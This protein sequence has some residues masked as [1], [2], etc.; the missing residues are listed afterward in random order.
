M[1]SPSRTEAFAA[2]TSHCYFIGSGWGDGALSHHM[3]TLARELARRG[4]RV[5]ML[6]HGARGSDDVEVRDRN[7]SMLSWPS[8]RPTTLADAIFLY[9]LARQHKPD[10][11]ISCFAAANLMLLVGRLLNVPCRV[12]W[13]QT[14]TTQIDIDWVES[15]WKMR[16]LQLRKRIVYKAATYVVAVSQ[17]AVEDARN[18]FGIPR[19][20]CQTFY[21]SLADPNDT[22]AVSGQRRLTNTV[23]CVGR[24][25]TSKGQDVLIRAVAAL[26]DTLPELRVEFVGSGVAKD[27]YARLAAD[28]EVTDRCVFAGKLPHAQI[29]A[30]MKSAVATV[31]PSRSDN[32]PLVIIE[33]LAVG[34]PV[35][36]S[37]VGG[38]GEMVRDGIDGLVCPPDDPRALAEA[39]KKLATDTDLRDTMSGNARRHFLDQFELRKSVREQAS[40]FE[41]VVARRTAAR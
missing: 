38:I 15:R 10:C 3:K 33:S 37:G 6:L 23:M 18:V 26:K 25:N 8:P 2:A 1:A 14:L 5:V 39:L 29:L 12:D 28:L 35:V 13:Y 19:R 40:W 41:S 32:C 27:D 34:T 30:K 17:A 9:R 7:L 11:M 21:N 36:A 16:L 22:V 24:L 4:N 31:V 20:K